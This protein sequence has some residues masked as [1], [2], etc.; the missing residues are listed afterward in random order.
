MH[1]RS[2]YQKE[3]SGLQFPSPLDLAYFISELN[4]PAVSM[5]GAEPTG[6]PEQSWDLTEEY[7]NGGIHEQFELCDEV[8]CSEHIPALYWMDF[9]RFREL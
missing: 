3:T 9:R 1:K 6:S 2:V 4:F 7:T 8:N 5:A